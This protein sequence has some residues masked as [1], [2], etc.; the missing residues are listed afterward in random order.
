MASVYIQDYYSDWPYQNLGISS[1]LGTV[2]TVV[3]SVKTTTD[4]SRYVY[5]PFNEP[6]NIWY[7]LNPSASNFSAQMA[8][9]EQDWATVYH[10]IRADDPG[11]LIAGPN[12]SY[13]D[14]TVMSDFLAYAKA[15][16]V[17]PD[18]ITWHE[19]SPSS[20]Q[21]YPANHASVV[22]LEKQD[23][24][25]PRPIDIDEYADR[26]DLSVPGRDGA[27]AGHVRGHQGLR[28]HGVLGHRQQLRRHRGRKRRAE[29]AV[30]AAATG[31]APLTGNT[32]AV[33]A[34][35]AGYDRHAAGPGRTRC[36]PKQARV[37]VADPSGG[38]DTVAITGISPAV[39]GSHVHVSVQSVA[40]S[41][42]DGAGLHAT[43][44]LAETELSRS[45]TGTVPC[46]SARSTRWPPTSS[47]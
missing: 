38:N 46:R 6:N 31:T 9:F 2:D 13:Y 45:S 15:S 25:S 44:T 41:G 1:Y 19:L 20:L 4:A 33:S 26:Y 23:G 21:N 3:A 8:Q 10:R 28:G 29:R 40:W 30:V 17:L 27:V 12:T 5:V 36:G 24:I 14:P 39:F 22:A 7:S 35:A 18:I 11:A 42:Y 34:A 16:D 37:I 47:S 43:P 32:V